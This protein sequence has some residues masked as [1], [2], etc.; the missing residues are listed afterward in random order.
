MP[1]RSRPGPRASTGRP[2]RTSQMRTM[3]RRGS[4][5][6]G[7]MFQRSSV[8]GRKFS[9]TTSAVAASRRNRS[10]PSARAQVERD[11]LAAAALDRPEQRVRAPSSSVDE[12][13]DLA[14]EVAAAGLLDLDDLGALLAEQAG[15]ERRGDAGAEVE[16]AQPRE[17][18]VTA[19]SPALLAL[20]RVHPAFALRAVDRARARSAVLITN[21]WSMKW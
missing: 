3:T 21:W 9:T 5:S 7:P 14:H 11:A 18:A 15:A 2:G 17:R 13:P 16:D 20:H 8:P 4:R 10:W 12:R 1:T 6:V 19:H